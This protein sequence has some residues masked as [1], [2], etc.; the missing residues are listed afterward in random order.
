MFSDDSVWF[1]FGKIIF[2]KYFVKSS[3]LFTTDIHILSW[4]KFCLKGRFCGRLESLQKSLTNVP[5]RVVYYSY[6]CLLCW[7]TT[8]HICSKYWCKTFP[9]FLI[10]FRQKNTYFKV[11]SWRHQVPRKQIQNN[12][13]RRSKILVRKKNQAKK[14]SFIFLISYLRNLCNI[15]HYEIYIYLLYTYTYYVSAYYYVSKS[16]NTLRKYR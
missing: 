5:S 2:Y 4:C 8:L 13:L 14:K 9:L 11:D 6:V 1:C 12:R 7:R 10:Y 16:I 15:F 3:S